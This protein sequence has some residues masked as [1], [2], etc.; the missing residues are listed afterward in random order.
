MQGTNDR[1]L[2]PDFSR[3]YGVEQA[4]RARLVEAFEIV[5]PTLS[6]ALAMEW[7]VT[8]LLTPNK[9]GD[10]TVSQLATVAADAQRMLRAETARGNSVRREEVARYWRTMRAATLVLAARS[11][12]KIGGPFHA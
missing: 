12:Q 6:E 8:S 10:L 5:E 7:T 2:T 9:L 11:V 1:P 4:E 3:P